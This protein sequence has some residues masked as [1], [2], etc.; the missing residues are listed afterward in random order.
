MRVAIVSN[1]D[2]Q[3]GAARASFR[4]MSALVRYGINCSMMV[5]DKRSCSEHVFENK[6][7]WAWIKGLIYRKISTSLTCFQKTSSCSL[8]SLNIFGSDLDK[9]IDRV[10]PSVVNLHWINFETLSIRQVAKL[11]QPVVLTLHDMWAFCGSEHLAKDTPDAAFRQGYGQG[12]EDYVSGLK[13]N[14]YIW[15][16][17]KKYWHRRFRIVA[18]SNWMATCAKESALF[19]GWDV[20]VIPNPLDTRVFRPLEQSFCR[21]V[22]NLPKDKKLIGFGAFGGVRDSNKG[23]DLL[24]QALL[25]LDD[26]ESYHCVVFGQSNASD[27][28][29]LPITA[30]Y[31]GHLSDDTSLSVV[32]NALDVM[33]IPSRQE[34]LPQTGTE[35]TA[36]GTPVVAF[37]TSGLL[38]VVEHMETGF[39][40]KPFD[41]SELANG[42]TWCIENNSNGRLSINSKKRAE[43]LWAYDIVAAQYTQLFET[44]VAKEGGG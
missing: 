23:F 42:I 28:S 18:P 27:S 12:S 15:K 20:S 4:L 14:K 22:F 30:T 2:T 37:K 33:V 44:V 8:H 10:E 36:C 16:L 5:K 31:L 3:G 35:A 7:K 24:E 1:S 21:K 34:N 19:N 13:L 9:I 11:K 43:K 29:K 26:K 41:T 40:A 39:L 25:S 17:K 6:S 32:Y 38:D